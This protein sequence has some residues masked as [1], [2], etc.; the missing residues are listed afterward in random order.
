MW[1]IRW[2]F[3]C[4]FPLCGADAESAYIGCRPS[5]RQ[6][7]IPGPLTWL[8][9]PLPPTN[10]LHPHSC[11]ERRSNLKNIPN[12]ALAKFLIFEKLDCHMLVQSVPL[13]ECLTRMSCSNC[14]CTSRKSS[15]FVRL[16]PMVL[17]LARVAWQIL[18]NHV[19]T[20]QNSHKSK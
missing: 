5:R 11:P 19:W 14:S 1:H 7:G 20:C 8:G 16:V 18:V 17:C 9:L 2:R 15:A 4:G 6:T 12:R 3:E 10:S 13:R